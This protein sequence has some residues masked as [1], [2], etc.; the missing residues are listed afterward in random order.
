MMPNKP[1]PSER[2]RHLR[3]IH[4]AHRDQD[5]YSQ[6]GE[7]PSSLEH[8]DRRCTTLQ[9][10]A[11]DCKEGSKLDIPFAAELVTGPA[12]EES[13]DCTASAE[14]TVGCGDD[15]GCLGGIS[16]LALGWEGEVGVPAWLTDGAGDNG[17]A[18]AI[19]LGSCG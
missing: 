9:H 8:L 1:T 15:M 19:G 18:V 6:P 4:R 12:H 3:H 10:T 11:Q 7:E 16:G 13:A 2:R 17:G 5:P 14:D